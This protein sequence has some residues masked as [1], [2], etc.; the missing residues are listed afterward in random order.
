MGGSYRNDLKEMEGKC[1]DSGDGKVGALANMMTNFWF[2][3]MLKV[4]SL[5][6]QK[7]ASISVLCSMELINTVGKLRALVNKY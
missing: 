5:S 3:K 2:Y 6:E 7:L 4:S 1:M